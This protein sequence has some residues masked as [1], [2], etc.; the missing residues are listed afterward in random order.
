M[1]SMIA[2]AVELPGGAD[3]QSLAR[4]MIEVHGTQA[5]DVARN[6]AREAALAAQ[7]PQAKS[8]IRVLALIQRQQADKQTEA[9]PARAVQPFTTPSFEA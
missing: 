9:F 1:A 2:E 5:A 3:A 4:D 8:W 6:N 7:I